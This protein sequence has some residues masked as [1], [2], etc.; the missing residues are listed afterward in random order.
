VEFVQALE[1]HRVLLM[2]D[3][4]VDHWDEDLLDLVALA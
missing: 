1:P 4:E 2:P 3:G